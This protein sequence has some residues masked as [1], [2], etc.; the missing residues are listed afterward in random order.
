MRSTPGSFE[1]GVTAYIPTRVSVSSPASCAFLICELFNLGSIDISGASGTY[2]DGIA[3]PTRT[4]LGTSTQIPG[5]CIMEATTAL[6]ATP[7]TLTTTYIDQSGN[8]AEAAAAQNLGASSTVGSCS[9][10]IPNSPDLGVTNITA[11]SRSGGTTPTG[12]ITYWGCIP[13]ALVPST[14]TVAVVDNLVQNGM[15]A[16]LGTSSTIGVFAIGSIALTAVAGFM[17]MVGDT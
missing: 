4:V 15:V 8:A 10:L 13:I 1:T 2:T 6:N 16:R 14:T 3:M 9:F 7:G 5:M 17:S 12:V 11:A